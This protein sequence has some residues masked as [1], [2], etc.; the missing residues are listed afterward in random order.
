[1]SLNAAGCAV[2]RYTCT[3]TPTTSKRPQSHHML[4]H[5]TSLKSRRLT[6]GAF[7]RGFKQ[8]A[9]ASINACLLAVAHT[10]ACGDSSGGREGL[11]ELAGL[12]K[13]LNDIAPATSKAYQRRS[14]SGGAAPRQNTKRTAGGAFIERH[15]HVWE[16]L[17]SSTMLRVGRRSSH[18]AARRVQ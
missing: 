4:L 17:S 1:M 15:R 6:R 16:Q 14:A 7:L 3:L 9:A 2:P 11:L 5:S 18:A 13:L 10:G 12:R 8:D